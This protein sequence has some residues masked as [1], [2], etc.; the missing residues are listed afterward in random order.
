MQNN[1]DELKKIEKFINFAYDPLRLSEFVDNSQRE[2]DE[3]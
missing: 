3:G 1:P 2:N